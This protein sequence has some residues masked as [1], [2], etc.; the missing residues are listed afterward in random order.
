MFGDC[1]DKRFRHIVDKHS[2][3][4]PS[5]NLPGHCGEN[6]CI[7]YALR[8]GGGLRR[9]EKSLIVGP[10]LRVC[11]L[12]HDLCGEECVS[13]HLG[14]QRTSD[15]EGVCDML[16]I[17]GNALRRQGRGDNPR[18][19]VCLSLFL[20]IRGNPRRHDIPRCVAQ[21]LAAK[22]LFFVTSTRRHAAAS[23][24]YTCTRHLRS[25]HR[26]ADKMRF[27]DFRFDATLHDSGYADDGEHDDNSPSTCTVSA[28]H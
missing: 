28:L 13:S 15:L 27:E 25:H 19:S 8:G 1:R 7:C 24:T 21:S 9:M 12:S 17:G 2:N 26:T 18:R 5:G 23:C 16:I 4:W 14:S 3:I 20:P 10:G 6:T 22:C 11:V